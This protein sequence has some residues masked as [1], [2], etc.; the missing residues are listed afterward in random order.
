M[1][2]IGFQWS[3]QRCFSD[4]VPTLTANAADYTLMIHGPN[5]VFRVNVSHVD[6]FPLSSEC[7]VSPGL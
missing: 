7:R 2:S 1:I 6:Q 4:K 3:V 5:A